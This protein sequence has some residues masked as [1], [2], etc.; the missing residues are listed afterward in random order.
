MELNPAPFLT[1]QGAIEHDGFHL[2][3]HLS[4]DSFI[5]AVEQQL[6]WSFTRAF[7]Q[8]KAAERPS[9]GRLQAPPIPS[10]GPLFWSCLLAVWGKLHLWVSRPRSVYFCIRRKGDGFVG[11][12]SLGQSKQRRSQHSKQTL[13]HVWT[14]HLEPYS[15]THSRAPLSVLFLLT[16]PFFFFLAQL[17][18]LLIPGPAHKSD[19]KSTYDKVS[20]PRRAD[21][22]RQLGFTRWGLC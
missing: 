21:F 18:T 7:W 2:K 1:H 6:F 16:P 17:N 20:P 22:S 14:T 12:G 5:C 3:T 4:K 8:E 15:P 10:F 9:P 11:G 19:R 13:P